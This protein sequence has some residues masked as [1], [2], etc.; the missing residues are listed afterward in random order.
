[1]LR[2]KSPRQ[3]ELLKYWESTLKGTECTRVE[4]RG[5]LPSDY[6]TSNFLGVE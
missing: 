1:M 3:T 5:A 6:S 2:F 4:H